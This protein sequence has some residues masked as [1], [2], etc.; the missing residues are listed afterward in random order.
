M[1]ST[2]EGQRAI[3]QMITQ[4][5]DGSFSVQFPG[6]KKPISVTFLKL[7]FSADTVTLRNPW[8][9]NLPKQ[10]PEPAIGLTTKGVTIVGGGELSMSFE[11]Y[12]VDLPVWF[13]S[14]QK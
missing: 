9:D 1:A 11:T 12:M 7:P 4:N 5:K 13:Y 8:G 6:E 2:K 10:S 14:E 3:A